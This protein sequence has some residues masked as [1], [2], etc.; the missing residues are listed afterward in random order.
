MDRRIELHNL[1]KELLGSDEV[2]FQKPEN[3][4]MNYPAIIYSPSRPRII[5]ADNIKYFKK[6]AYSVIVIDRDPDSEISEKIS[7]LEHC[8]WERSYSADNLNHFVYTLYF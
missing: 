7:E 5:H 2:Y 6:K 8:A 3:R 4:K 1:L